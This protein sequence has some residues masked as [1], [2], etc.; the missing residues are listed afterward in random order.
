M[1]ARELWGQQVGHKSHKEPSMPGGPP[2]QQ[3][4]ARLLPGQ[5]FSSHSQLKGWHEAPLCAEQRLDGCVVHASEALLDYCWG[6]IT[7]LGAL[8]AESR[9][10]R[11]E[12]EVAV[13][14]Q[15]WGGDFLLCSPGSAGICSER[16]ARKDKHRKG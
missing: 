7:V 10:W 9:L 1:P 6:L 3:G 8:G 15:P 16:D 4:L 14:W 11:C 12:G 5:E 13:S 2:Q